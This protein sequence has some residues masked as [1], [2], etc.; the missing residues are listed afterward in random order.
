MY[1]GET[2]KRNKEL[3]LKSLTTGNGSIRLTVG[4]SL[5]GCRVDCKNGIFIVHL[6]VPFDLADY[7]QHIG[8]AGRGHA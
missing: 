8:R 4:T 5:L 3:V 2:I 6:G 7:A 1:H